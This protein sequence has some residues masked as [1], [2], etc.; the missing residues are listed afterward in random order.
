[1]RFSFPHKLPHCEFAAWGQFQVDSVHHKQGDIVIDFVEPTKSQ[2]RPQLSAYKFRIF[3]IYA[4]IKSSL[5][6]HSYSHS[7]QRSTQK[8]HSAGLKMH[9]M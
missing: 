8:T 5:Y 3:T 2:R 4:L 9:K 1:M 6:G 7:C